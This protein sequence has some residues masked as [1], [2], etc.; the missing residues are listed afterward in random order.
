[1]FRLVPDAGAGQSVSESPFSGAQNVVTM[2]GSERWRFEA[3]Y[4]DLTGADRA[5]MQAFIVRLRVSRNV[6]L[7]ANPTANN[8][9]VLSGTPQVGVASLAGMSMVMY[10]GP[11]N[12]SSWAC[13]GDFI[14][15]NSMLKMVTQNVGTNGSG[16]AS[17]EVWPPLFKAPA[18]GTSII[19]NVA[20]A[21]GAFRLTNA[22]MFN[23]EPPGYRLSLSISAVEHISSSYVSELL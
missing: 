22:A 9:G 20:S 16:V 10:G 13:A 11:N 4:S 18:S 17:L 2:W 5:E 8:R 23:T 3:T 19:V 15:V 6:F 12:V 14:A 7:L 1:V 21:R